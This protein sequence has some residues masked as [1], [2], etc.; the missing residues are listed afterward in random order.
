MS[1][2]DPEPFLWMIFSAGG[3]VSA[4][5]MPS[6]LVFFGLAIPFGWIAAPSLEHMRAVLANPLTFVVM[7]SLLVLSFFH[8]AHRL[9]H[10]LYD[11]LQIKH[12][13]GLVAALCYGAAV[14]GS[15]AATYFLWQAL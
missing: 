1:K 15:G 10:T 11:C 13:G 12:L 6:L 2:R 8:S 5:L 7:L 3:V 9:R 14:V 4:M